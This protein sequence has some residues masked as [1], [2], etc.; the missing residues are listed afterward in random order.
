MIRQP[1]CAA[2]LMLATAVAGAGG[3][4]DEKP[5]GAVDPVVADRQQ[6]QVAAFTERLRKLREAVPAPKK[7]QEE[8]CPDEDLEQQFDGGYGAMLLVDYEFLDRYG[9]DADGVYSGERSRWSFLSGRLLRDIDR[10]SRLSEAKR[11]VETLIHVQ[12]LEREYEYVAVLRTQRREAPRLEGAKF[13]GGEFEAWLVVFEWDTL[14]R[15]CQA[16]IIA[17]SS[18]EVAG[19]SGQA[20][21]QVLWRDFRRR[22]DL[23]MDDAVRR[24]TRRLLLKED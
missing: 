6:Q 16:E 9:R 11:N 10:A 22:I 3:G 7:L 19:I 12:Q 2:L 24:L 1:T 20:R 14:R 23:G 18:T 8:P 5:A 4:C 17:Q 21:D 15:L 13:H